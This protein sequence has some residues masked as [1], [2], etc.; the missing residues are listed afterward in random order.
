[1]SAVPAGF[2]D[3][4]TTRRAYAEG[5]FAAAL[6]AYKFFYPDVSMEA[7]MQGTRAAGARDNEAFIVLDTTPRHVIYT[8]NSDT[9]YGGTVL[10]LAEWGPVVIEIPAGPYVALVD[11]HHRWVADMGLPGPDGG[12][13][14][15]HLI[16][17]PGW[18]GDVP[19]G[20]RVA[21]APTWKV[22]V[23]LR[24]LPV[25]GP[26]AALAALREVRVYPLDHPER[27]D[28][29]GFVDV[30]DQDIDLTPRAWEDNLAYW[31][32]LHRI[33]DAEPARD[34]Y[35]PMY[36]L[37]AQLGIAK[38]R[39]FAPDAERRELLARAARTGRDQLLATTFDGRRPERSVWEDR[40]WE[41]VGLQ[42]A[43][44]D[45]EDEHYLDTEARDRWFAQA[46]VASPA[47]FR[48]KAGSGSLYWLAARDADGAWLDGS[49]TY[50]LRV[51]GPVPAGLFWSLTVY[52]SETRSQVVTGRGRAAMRSLY[53]KP[54]PDLDGTVDLYVGPTPPA[55]QEERRLRTV[56]GRGWFAYF[57]IY[58]P[59]EPAFDG[60]WRP[61]DFEAVPEG[62]G[63]SV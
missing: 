47:M 53:E 56:P 31:E 42:P 48:R 2:P 25:D 29:Y 14:G 20:C 44:G 21:H 45:F 17:P 6:V 46:V 10:D 1:M 8:P 57:R 7:L 61:G 28:A 52:D 15:R 62:D 24:R 36:G 23:V 55:G 22:Y 27:A 34:E 33:V 13:G 41:W 39:P 12:A 49:R 11:D 60:S 35:R 54:A 3:P 63:P 37:L 18:E 30:C 5:D 59:A 26:E 51:P 19:E 32:V 16:C 43:N 4:E 40:R 9:P 38:G 58:G 50:R